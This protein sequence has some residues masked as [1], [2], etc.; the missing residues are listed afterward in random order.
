MAEVPLT[1]AVTADVPGEP[2]I[3]SSDYVDRLLGRAGQEEEGALTASHCLAGED[4]GHVAGQ[5]E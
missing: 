2:A 1:E 5:Q 3:V 4:R